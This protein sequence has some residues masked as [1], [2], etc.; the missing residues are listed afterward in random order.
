[1]EGI[2]AIPG[3]YNSKNW[4]NRQAEARSA[5]HADDH[6]SQELAGNQAD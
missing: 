5:G 4:R 2:I 3:K 6:R 1:V